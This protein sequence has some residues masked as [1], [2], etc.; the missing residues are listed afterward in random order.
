MLSIK[1]SSI[2]MSEYPR[3]RPTLPPML[4][5]T[6]LKSRMKY[7]D[8]TWVLRSKK[9]KS[10]SKWLK[11]KNL[12]QVGKP[13]WLG[14][15]STYCINKLRERYISH[16]WFTAHK[17]KMRYWNS[18]DWDWRSSTPSELWSRTVVGLPNRTQEERSGARDLLCLYFGTY[19][20]KQ[21]WMTL[22]KRGFNAPCYNRSS[23]GNVSYKESKR[24]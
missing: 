14:T 18:I 19:K 24:G 8:S 5:I 1:P 20:D 6:E 17:N 11:Y 15:W 13:T 3:K 16:T 10:S 7:S 9:Q 12:W 21:H 4:V 2:V 22:T 23:I